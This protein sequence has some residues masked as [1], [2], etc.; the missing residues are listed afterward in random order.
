[1]DVLSPIAGTVRGLAQVPDPVFSAAMV[2]PGLAVEPAGLEPGP[3]LAPAAGTLVTLHAHA[4]VIATPAGAAVL[5]HLG[6]DTV[7]M[8]GEG[9]TLRAA[10]GDRVSAGQPIVVWHPEDVVR[11]GL[12]TV[13]PVI[14]LDAAA[15]DL[16]RLRAEGPVGTQ[17]VLFRWQARAPEAAGRPGPV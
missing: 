4:F 5:V 1:V 8:R 3:V 13:C 6:I 15:G 7:S 11:R 17:E 9:F 2:G 16:V 10:A 12:S 14:A